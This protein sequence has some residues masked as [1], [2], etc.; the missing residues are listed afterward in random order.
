MFWFDKSNPNVLFQD[1]RT[2]TCIVSDSS[3]KTGQREI[4]V[5]PDIEGDFTSMNFLDESFSLVVF[6]PPHMSSLG[7]N[8]W[9]A[10]K[11]GRLDNDWQDVIRDGFSEC[12][13]VLKE[14]GIL[15]FKWNEYDIPL[16]KVL[17][18]SEELPLFGHPSGKQQKTHWICFMKIK[19]SAKNPSYNKHMAVQRVPTLHANCEQDI[20]LDLFATSPC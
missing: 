6:D 1:I 10:K 4:I 7:A 12:F 11:Y 13:R 2:E 15:I 3:Q 18:L 9:M 17:T 20:V 19:G 5:K 14:N 16:K 8:S